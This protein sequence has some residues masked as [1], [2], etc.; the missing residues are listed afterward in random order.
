[1]CKVKRHVFHRDFL[2]LNYEVKFWCI[3]HKNFYAKITLIIDLFF[4]IIYDCVNNLIAKFQ[5]AKCTK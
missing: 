3:Y 4:Y 5:K 2:T 1:M